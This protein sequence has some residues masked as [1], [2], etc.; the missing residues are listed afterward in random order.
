MLFSS[1]PFLY[2]FLPVTLILYGLVP[3]K[4]KNFILLMTS[5]FF[6]GWGEPKTILLMILSITVGYFVG[7]K[8]EQNLGIK[9][10]KRWLIVSVI[11]NLGMLGLFKYADFFISKYCFSRMGLL[12]RSSFY[13]PDNKKDLHPHI[14]Y[15]DESQR[16]RVTTLL[17]RQLALPALFTTPVLCGVHLQNSRAKQPFHFCTFRFPFIV[18]AK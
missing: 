14:T 4:G 2:Y 6:Y 10:A 8:I 15:K 9:V 11:F 1:L 7:I 17:H 13:L 3:K 18:L 12:I 16:L 5:L